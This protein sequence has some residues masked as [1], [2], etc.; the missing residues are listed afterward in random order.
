[1][2]KRH[3]LGGTLGS[4]A[5]LALLIC[6]L[7]GCGK[8]VYRGEPAT[9]DCFPVKGRVFFEGKPCK[10][11]TVRLHPLD[12]DRKVVIPAKLSAKHQPTPAISPR[13]DVEESGE[14]VLTTFD[15]FDGAPEGK[16]A[17]T[18]SW[19]DPD[20]R[21]GDDSDHYPELLPKRYQDPAQSGLVVEIKP[22]D[23][24]VLPDFQLTP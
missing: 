19:K 8:E 1:M 4:R 6:L 15:T 20:G 24:N 7:G 9:D 3:L 16:Y 18:I 21:G 12:P 11:A 22:E 13:A 17:V 14:F 5:G 23:E 10:N 2:N